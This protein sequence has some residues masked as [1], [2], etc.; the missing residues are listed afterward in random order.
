MGAPSAALTVPW[1]APLPPVR[2]PDWVCAGTSMRL[3]SAA[4]R[5]LSKPQ[6][7]KFDKVP[8]ESTALQC[9]EIRHELFVS[10]GREGVLEAR[11]VPALP[12]WTE[13][14]GRF[15]LRVA[16]SRTSRPGL[17]RT[18]AAGPAPR[19]PEMA[20]A[21]SSAWNDPSPRERGCRF[22]PLFHG[23]FE[24]SRGL[25]G[26]RDAFARSPG[27]GQERADPRVLPRRLE[28]AGPAPQPPS[29]SRQPAPPPAPSG[30]PDSSGFLPSY[31]P[32]Q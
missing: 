1:I 31:T 23:D 5:P 19:S 32:S 3:L 27:S 16:P 24:L 13:P 2:A 21:A 30:I 22:T 29:P 15:P 7:D 4:S 11:H 17:A 12:R 6:L 25:T 10:V 28:A 14:D 18:I 8:P 26:V 20:E 9:L